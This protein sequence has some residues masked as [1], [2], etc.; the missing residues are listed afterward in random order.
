[1][2]KS[3]NRQTRCPAE[4]IT[5]RYVDLASDAA[6]FR[7]LPNKP[8]AGNLFYPVIMEPPL[9]AADAHFFERFLHA[10]TL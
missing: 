6:F 3:P 7:E 4:T 5:I 9:S 2:R 8:A 10:F 1:M